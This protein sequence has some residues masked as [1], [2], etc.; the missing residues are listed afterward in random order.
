MKNSP[1]IDT[2]KPVSRQYE[3]DYLGY[4]GYPM[5]WDG[6]GLWGSGMYPYALSPG[7]PVTA[8]DGREREERINEI[9]AMA[10]ARHKNDDPNLRSCSAVVG[11]HVHAT[12]GDIGHIAG[13]LVDEQTWAIRYIVINTSNWWVGHQVLIAP[14]WITAVNWVD[15]SVTVELNRESIQTA[16]NFD[17]TQALNREQE[18]GLYHHHKRHGYWIDTAVLEREI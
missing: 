12:D 5:Y 18:T 8:A 6:D 7:Y 4:Y 2:H 3:I 1:D 9:A 16:P 15:Q 11:Y 17:S 10:R 13:L 14:Q